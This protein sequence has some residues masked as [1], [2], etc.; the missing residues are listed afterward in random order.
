[1]AS[2]QKE[3]GYTPTANELIE[4][5]CCLEV[6]GACHRILRF[7][8]RKTYGYRK[9]EDSISLSQFEKGTGMRR[10]TVNESLNTLINMG[11]IV[12][13]KGGYINKYTIEKDYEKWTSNQKRTSS[14]NQTKTSNQKRTKTSSQKR[15][16]KRKKERKKLGESNS[17]LRISEDMDFKNK[18]YKGEEGGYDEPALDIETGATVAPKGKPKK[19]TDEMKQV[20][21]LFDNPAKAAW[22]LREIER[23][24]AQALFDTYGIETLT[25]RL[26]RIKKEQAN[27]DPLFPLITTPS[28]LLDKMPN[29]ERYLNI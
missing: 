12:K 13:N 5:I 20:F 23:V 4:A 17:P 21:N 3:N 11:V 16:H 27:K 6:S 9:K 7:I 8:E 2:P 25:K 14:Q 19:V 22:P 10:N 15:T 24:C 18:N 26:E 1:M 28:Q 29:V